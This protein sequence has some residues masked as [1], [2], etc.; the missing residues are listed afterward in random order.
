VIEVRLF[1]TLPM[2]SQKGRKQFEVEPHP[3]L[4]V[5]DV[6]AGE[7]LDESEIHLVMINGSHGTLDSP[8]SDGDRLGLF[9][10]IGGG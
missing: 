7:G 6:I 5:R 8:L 2:R 10:P 3:G 9:P 4:S 1:A